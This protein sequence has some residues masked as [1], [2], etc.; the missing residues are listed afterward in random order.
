MEFRGQ[1]RGVT[2]LLPPCGS[3][4]IS[5]DRSTST[6]SACPRSRVINC[7]EWCPDCRLALAG[8][9]LVEAP[10]STWN[11]AVPCALCPKAAENGCGGKGTGSGGP[12]G[13]LRFCVP[14]PPSPASTL[15]LWVAWVGDREAGPIATHVLESELTEPGSRC[16]VTL[17]SCPQ[18]TK[19]HTAAQVPQCSLR[20]IFA[21]W[22]GSSGLQNELLCPQVQDGLG[23]DLAAG[24]QVSDQHASLF[25]EEREVVNKGSSLGWGPL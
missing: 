5:L 14:L 2:S 7:L 8:H 4:G 25:L 20:H 6:Q 21:V 17:L 23:E 9:Q 16:Q 19:L 13:H 18:F 12:P 22:V 24:H 15:V 10:N 11:A 1:F 3:W